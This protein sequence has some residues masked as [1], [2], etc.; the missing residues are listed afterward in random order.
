MIQTGLVSVTFREFQPAQIVNLVQQAGLQAIEWGGDVHVPH[1][2]IKRAREVVKITLEA[3]LQVAAYGS[4]YK[5]GCED[6][7]IS[8]E[9]VLETA[10]EL[11][12]PS[13]R[14]WAGDVGSDQAEA[15]DWHRVID[16]ARRIS[17]LAA[18]TGINLAFEYHEKTLTDTSEAALRLLKAIDSPNILSY[19]QPPVALDL[20]A[21]LAGL[22]EIAP[23]LSNL[24]VFNQTG[25]EPEPLAEGRDEW[26]KYMNI[27]REIPGDRFCMLEFVKGNSTSQFFEDAEALKSICIDAAIRGLA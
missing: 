8:F 21:R 20:D 11:Q 9:K 1:G 2:D 24:H 6:G 18:K 10:V 12:A 26:S 13:L 5:A 4:Y 16:D 22:R 14:I 23:W 7:T 19:W 25:E 27:V 15:A 17:A 3:G